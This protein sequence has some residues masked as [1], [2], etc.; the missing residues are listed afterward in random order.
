M[1]N[2]VLFFAKN[3]KFCGKTKLFKLLYFADFKHFRE[4]GRSITGMEYNAWQHGPYPNEFAKELVSPPS[5]L[6][7]TIAL[8]RP[9][10]TSSFTRIQPKAKFNGKYFTK[11]ELRILKEVE[12]VFMEAQ[13][14]DI[15]EASHLKNH[16]WDI[17]IKTKGERKKIDYMLALDGAKGSLTPEEVN[18]II[19]ERKE[20]LKA[21][22]E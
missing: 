1:L 13:A 12:E 5:D 11:R 9:S 8:V 18:E 16:P 10:N 22:N 14:K 21:F 15:R 2:A 4:T 6:S 19:L 3:T 7:R 17:T 20:L